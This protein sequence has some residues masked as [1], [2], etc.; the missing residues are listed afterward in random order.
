M[1]PLC[2]TWLDFRAQPIGKHGRLEGFRRFLTCVSVVNHWTALVVYLRSR[3]LLCQEV[4]HA[5]KHVH[6]FQGPDGAVRRKIFDT[7]SRTLPRDRKKE[8]QVE[9]QSKGPLQYLS[10]PGNRLSEVE[11]W[12]LFWWSVHLTLVWLYFHQ[13]FNAVDRECKLCRSRYYSSKVA[14][15]KNV[16]PGKWWGEVKNIAGMTPSAGCEEIQSHIHTD[17]TVE[18]RLSG[19]VGTTQNSPDNRESG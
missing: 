11:A 15:L 8:E 1:N 2:L 4:L 6:V 12:T 16:K 9:Y 7:L 10:I 14:D 5:P 18:P 13:H 3:V 17:G 19:L